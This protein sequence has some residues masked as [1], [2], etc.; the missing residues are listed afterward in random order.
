MDGAPGRGF[1]DW[2]A[3]GEPWNSIVRCQTRCGHS[4][5]QHYRCPGA[6]SVRRQA[7]CRDADGL[8]R[9][10]VRIEHREAGAVGIGDVRIAEPERRLRPGGAGRG[11]ALRIEVGAAPLDELRDDERIAAFDQPVDASAFGQ[12]IERRLSNRV[13]YAVRWVPRHEHVVDVGGRRGGARDFDG[14]LVAGRNI[15]RLLDVPET[16]R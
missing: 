1:T 13:P 5:H 6:V 8:Q 4:R 12:E 9:V 10:E 7:G 2:N 15:E 3:A 16:S 14:E 11:Q